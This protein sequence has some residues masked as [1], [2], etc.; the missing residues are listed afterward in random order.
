MG[1]WYLFTVTSAGANSF[2][3]N[4]QFVGNGNQGAMGNLQSFTLNGFRS[5]GGSASQTA[6]AEVRLYT[7]GMDNAKVGTLYQTVK[8]KWGL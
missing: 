5:V 1:D 3:V 4:D 6:F 2:Y 8:T 7:S